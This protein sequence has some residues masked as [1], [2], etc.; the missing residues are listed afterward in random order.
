MYRIKRP[1]H[2][3]KTGL[4]NGLRSQI[5][6]GFPNKK[7]TILAITGTDGKTTSSTLLYHTLKT[8]GIKVALLST[9]AAYVGDESIDTGFHV[10]TPSPY[11]LQEFMAKMVKEN[12]THL[13]LEVTS[14]GEYQYRTWGVTPL[15]AGLTNIEHEHLDYHVT[16]DEYLKAKVNFLKKAP[17]IVLN[18]DI[19]VY[20]TVKRMLKGKELLTFNKDS[21][22]SKKI[23]S[24]IKKRFPEYYNQY[25]AKL[26]TTICQKL[27]MLEDSIVEGV[28]TFAGVPGRYQQIPNKRNIRVIVDFA[29]T[30]QALHAVLTAAKS[31]MK[32]GKLITMFGCAGMRDKSKRPVM[33][34]DAVEIADQVILTADDPRNE[35]V[36][37]IIRQMKEQLTHGHERIISIPNRQKAI[38]Y[39]INTLA[40]P[41]DTVVLA[42]KGHEKS[43]AYDNQEYPWDE[44][45]IAA[46]ALAKEPPPFDW[47]DTIE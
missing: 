19:K 18:E 43:I 11:K 23:D 28:R 3:V 21:H 25:N 20:T 13:V 33:T 36:W 41:G 9:V 1:Y 38:Y 17:T 40:K 4:L 46:A 14:H 8:A 5:K 42:S 32:S 44:A 45:K 26:V 34:Q 27:E 24:A 37:S 35:D 12:I 15:I 31:E 22:F 6:F 2:F 16:F 39:A 7:L 29:H 10:T 47:Y 30:P